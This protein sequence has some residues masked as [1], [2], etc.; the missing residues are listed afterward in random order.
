M[1]S[2]P[3]HNASRPHQLPDELVA[4]PSGSPGGVDQVEDL[5]DLELPGFED[6]LTVILPD[7]SK[8]R[9]ARSR[10]PRITTNAP[11]RPGAFFMWP[12]R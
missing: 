9:C 4:G 3:A 5:Q 8:T 10:G 7:Y 2:P 11:E 1:A 6:G 12:Q